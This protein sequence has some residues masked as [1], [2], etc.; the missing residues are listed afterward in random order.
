[1]KFSLSLQVQPAKND[2][3]SRKEKGGW[4]CIR[5]YFVALFAS[6]LIAAAISFFFMILLIKYLTLKIS[7][8]NTE[9]ISICTRNSCIIY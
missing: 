9:K 4:E 7:S 8:V 1:M 5:D 3:K 6:S 2:S